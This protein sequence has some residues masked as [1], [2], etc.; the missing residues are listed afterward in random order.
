MLKWK[1]QA[2]GLMLKAIDGGMGGA[3]MESDPSGK[4]PHPNPWPVAILIS[5][6]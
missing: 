5:A 4:L 6:L 1:N 2:L 3:V